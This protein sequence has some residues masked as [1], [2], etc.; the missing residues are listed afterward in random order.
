MVFILFLY[1]F[2]LM[3]ERRISAIHGIKGSKALNAWAMVD[4]QNQPIIGITNWKRAKTPAIRHILLCFIL[5]SC[6]PFAIETEKASI[7][8]PT[9]KS[10][11]LK[12]KLKPSSIYIFLLSFDTCYLI[13]PIIRDKVFNVKIRLQQA[14]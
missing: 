3:K 11:L 2:L 8:R 9:P 12:K 13:H 5:G 7:A 14:L 4:T 1:F 6:R 10:V